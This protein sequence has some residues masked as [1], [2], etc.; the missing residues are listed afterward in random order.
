MS[1]IVLNYLESLST[2]NVCQNHRN[3]PFLKKPLICKDIDAHK[4]IVCILLPF[5]FCFHSGMLWT[6]Y[7]VAVLSGTA[8]KEIIY[9]IVPTK[10]LGIICFRRYGTNHFG[11]Y[12]TYCRN[13]SFFAYFSILFFHLLLRSSILFNDGNF[14]PSSTVSIREPCLTLLRLG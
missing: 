5:W 9:N 14:F 7:R 8:I 3:E 2:K 6:F 10:L 11:A 13:S 4:G 1:A 12:T